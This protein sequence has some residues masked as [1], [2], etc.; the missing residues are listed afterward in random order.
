MDDKINAG[1][2]MKFCMERYSSAMDI[3]LE[4]FALGISLS[5]HGIHTLSLMAI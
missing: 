2:A 1:H 5:E 4:K 3:H